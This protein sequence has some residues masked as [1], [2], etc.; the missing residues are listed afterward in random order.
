MLQDTKSQSREIFIGPL[1]RNVKCP[2]ATYGNV[3]PEIDIVIQ[4]I[5]FSFGEM[6]GDVL[7]SMLEISCF[8]HNVKVQIGMPGAENIREAEDTIATLKSVC[9]ADHISCRKIQFIEDPRLG[10][11]VPLQRVDRISVIR[12]N[13]R[14]A[15]RGELQ[16][17]GQQNVIVVSV[18]LGMV[19]IPPTLDIFI[20]AD[21]I[22]NNDDIDVICSNGL[23]NRPFGYYDIFAT[24]LKDGTFLYPLS[25]RLEGSPMLNEDENMIR[26]NEIYGNITQEDFYHHFLK[27]GEQSESGLVAVDSCFGGLTLYRA[28]RWLN[29]E[30]SYSLDYEKEKFSGYANLD[31]G[32]PCEHVRFHDCIKRSRSN[33]S[34]IYIQSS[35]VTWWDTPHEPLSYISSG[36]IIEHGLTNPAHGI[37]ASARFPRYGGRIL[38]NGKF[39]L[40]IN[41]SGSL[42]AEE[43][44]AGKAI[45]NWI[46]APSVGEWDFM[47]LTLAE[48]GV[49]TL[50]KQ[51]SQDNLCFDQVG[52]SDRNP[53]RSV[54]WRS[55]RPRGSPKLGPTILHLHKDGILRIIGLRDHKILW[56]NSEN[57]ATCQNVDKNAL[58]LG[59]QIS[60]SSCI[61]SGDEN[62]IND[63]LGADESFHAEAVLCQG[64]VFK[65]N[66][67]VVFSHPLQSLYTDGRPTGAGRAVLQI[68][69]RLLCTAVMMADQDSVLLESVVIDGNAPMYGMCEGGEYL[70]ALIQAGGRSDGTIVRNVRAF[71]SRTWSTLH[72]R[73]GGPEKEC[74]DALVENNFFGPSGEHVRGKWSD[75]ISLACTESIVRQNIVEDVTDVGIVV[76]GAPQSLVENNNILSRTQNMNAGITMVDYDPYLGDFSETVV[77]RNLIHADGALV[78]VGFAMGSRTWKCEIT[79]S[80]FLWGAK[81]NNNILEGDMFHGFVVNGVLEWEIQNNV[82][83]STKQCLAGLDT[84][85]PG[86]LISAHNS[87]GLF[88]KE[89]KDGGDPC[90][91]VDA[92]V[93]QV[94]GSSFISSCGSFEFPCFP[95]TQGNDVKQGFFFVKIPKTAGTTVASV[96]RRIVSREQRRLGYKYPCNIRAGHGSPRYK[97]KYSE[98][99]R[100]QSFLFTFI[101]EPS[102]RLVSSYY[103]HGVAKRGIQAS[104]DSFLEVS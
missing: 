9:F 96:S 30:C 36:G 46:V 38:K 79:D 88:Q 73:E 8:H 56:C 76:F 13:L 40:R 103:Y 67:P 59:P 81:V 18:D 17:Q 24:V 54:L 93:E 75:G 51:T 65:L 14:N 25:G 89:F 72:I 28:S 22:G 11:E 21:R 66:G 29:T 41:S 95:R 32:R 91:I 98:R 48:D 37:V 60:G 100:A 1:G 97:Y 53:C 77:Q 102:A 68:T 2:K 34:S 84:S 7:A 64:A 80:S 104:D 4:G 63:V 16:G 20:E 61:P 74:T 49:L 47:F 55:P 12:E 39:S 90:E 71:H 6:T 83:N 50:T 82:D 85:V 45:I 10:N 23:M 57:T 78:L 87:H 27:E 42:V 3:F 31:D 52:D 58:Q 44:H 101:R 35:L 69:N 15:L 86:F 99:D 92:M 62:S 94:S 5:V 33:V 70:G 26:S 43:S 19:S